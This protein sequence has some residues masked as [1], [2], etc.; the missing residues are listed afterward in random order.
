MLG[1]SSGG[2]LHAPG[3]SLAPPWVPGPLPPAPVPPKTQTWALH[4]LAW[5]TP[6]W[7]GASPGLPRL[8][9]STHMLSVGG[10]TLAPTSELGKGWGLRGAGVGAQMHSPAGSIPSARPQAFIPCPCWISARRPCSDLLLRE[11]QSSLLKMFG[12]HCTGLTCYGGTLRLR[13]VRGQGGSPRSPGSIWV[14]PCDGD[15][16][17]PWAPSFPGLPSAVPWGPPACGSEA[18]PDFPQTWSSAPLSQ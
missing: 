9:P 13:G 1:Y 15:E 3:G 4:L 18:A 14:G 2:E 7:P 11:I 10:G 8:S 17:P 5:V 6:A 12:T 16:H